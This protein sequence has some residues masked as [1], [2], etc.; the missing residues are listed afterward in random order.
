[1][2]N[3]LDVILKTI[4]DVQQKNK[5]SNNTATADPSVFDLLREKIGE[6]DTKHQN[7]QMQ[8]GRKNPK[9]ILDIIKNGIEGARKE[10]KKDPN[11]ETAPSSIFDDILKKVDQ[12]PKR[13]ASTGIKK[14]IQ[15]Y[16]LDVSKIPSNMLQEIQG[17]FEQDSQKL[18]QQY[19]QGIFD[20]TKKFK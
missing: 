3:I 5:Q 16:N 12:G 7:N 13:Q 14:I 10:N 4:N 15:D 20:L 2:A 6:I 17:Q 9:S 11:V 19:A 18:K 1:M 8:K